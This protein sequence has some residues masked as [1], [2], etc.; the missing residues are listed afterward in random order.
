M[1][2]IDP[3]FRKKLQRVLESWIEETQRYLRKAQVEGYLRQGVDV[4]QVAR[5][6]VMSEEGSAAVVKNLR[7]RDV[8][9]AFYEGFRHFLE[10]ISIRPEGVPS[11]LSE[12]KSPP[13]AP[14]SR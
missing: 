6:V 9:R 1:S 14:H 4:K 13:S 10:S 11:Q 8:Y 7:D 3:V 2:A 5:F 12:L